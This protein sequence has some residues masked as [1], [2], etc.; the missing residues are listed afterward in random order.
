MTTASKSPPHEN[1]IV[2]ERGSGSDMALLH[3]AIVARGT[4]KSGA[5]SGVLKRSDT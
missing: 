4:D 2:V 5:T 3:Q 1:I